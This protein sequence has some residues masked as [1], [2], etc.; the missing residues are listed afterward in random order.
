[1]KLAGYV[2]CMVEM[3]NA[4]SVFIGKREERRPVG[5]LRVESEIKL[6][7]IFCKDLD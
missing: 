7:I 1:M 2:E 3:R 5:D 4:Y 6:N